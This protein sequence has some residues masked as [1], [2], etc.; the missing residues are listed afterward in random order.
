MAIRMVIADDHQLVREGTRRILEREPDI[1]VV[2]EAATAAEAL[3]L[4]RV[5]HPDVALLDMRLPDRSG[6][7]VVR[8]LREEGNPARAVLLS[9]FDD[10]EYVVEALSAGAAGYLIK[11]MPSDELAGWVR[12]AAEGDAAL[13]PRLA[14]RIARYVGRVSTKVEEPVVSAREIAVL[15]LLARGLP[16]KQIAR[17]LGISPRTV[18]GHLSHI[19]NKLGVGS[20]TEALLWALDHGIVPELSEAEAGERV[21]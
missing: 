11:T 16:N 1:E 20:R 12:R 17:R 9:A 15:G 6:I 5:L 19:F 4:T 3:E 13:E 2:G 21:E 14:V 18:E 10:E 7:D 8:Q